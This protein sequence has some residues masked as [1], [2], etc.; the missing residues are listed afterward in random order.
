MKLKLKSTLL[1]ILLTLL[2]NNTLLAANDKNHL[3][4]F[5]IN[6]P[7]WIINEWNKTVKYQKNGFIEMKSQTQNTKKKINK[8]FSHFK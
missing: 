6:V 5:R 2:N 4:N 1:I 3:N 7:Q 8:I